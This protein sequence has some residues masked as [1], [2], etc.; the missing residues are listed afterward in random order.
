MSRLARPLT[1]N[2]ALPYSPLSSIA[3]FDTGKNAVA[4]IALHL[5]KYEGYTEK[6]RHYPPAEF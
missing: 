1:V 2:E 3:P 6:D 4:P 5:H